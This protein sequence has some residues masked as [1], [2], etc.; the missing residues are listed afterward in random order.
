MNLTIRKTCIAVLAV[1]LSVGAVAQSTSAK[2]KYISPNND[3]AK[4]V[5]TIPFKISDKSILKSWSLVIENSKGKVVRT[6]GNKIALPSTVTLKGIVSQIGK[7]KEGVEVPPEVTWNGVMDDGQTAPDGEYFYYF[8]AVDEN[9]NEGKTK[10]HSVIVDNT[11]PEVK[12]TVPEEDIH[13]FGE[14]DKAD[15]TIKQSG[16]KEDL[17]VATI[18]DAEGNVVRTMKWEND[19]PT[20]FVWNGTDDNGVI[21]HDGVYK[22]AI[23]SEDRAG[24]TAN[25]TEVNNIAFSA[26]KPVTNIT[27]NGSKYFSLPSKSKLSKIILDVTIPEPRANSG[28]KQIGRASC[29][30]RV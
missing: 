9:N 17:W 29:R 25:I 10:K 18:I 30:E 14:G 12:V 7:A 22:Y 23:T 8:V 27:I 28:N 11:K 3:G 19:G 1:A 24:N 5:L 2:Q 20:T 4:D 16:S 21:V 13:V 26:E 6:I 15:F